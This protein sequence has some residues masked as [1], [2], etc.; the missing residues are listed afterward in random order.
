MPVHRLCSGS[1]EVG[2]GGV[3][4]DALRNGAR[5]VAAILRLWRR[6][7]RDRR[8]L[9]RLDAGT[10]KDIGVTVGDAEM[11]INKPFWRE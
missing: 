5:A 9:A 7:R 8:E 3:A 6:R 11:L 1:G 10:L 2:A 4:F